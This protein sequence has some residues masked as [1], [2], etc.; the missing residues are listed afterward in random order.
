MN[1]NVYFEVGIGETEITPPEGITGRLG[2]NHTLY[3]KHPIF[4][5]ALAFKTKQGI[6][7]Q[8]TCELVGLTRGTISR[9]HTKLENELGLDRNNIILTC[10]HTHC[11]PWI[12]DLQAKEA[13]QVGI[14]LLDW[15]WL[16]K[17]IQGCVK[18]AQIAIENFQPSILK[19]GVAKVKDVASN[20]IELG[21]RGSICT[22]S[23][24][25]AKGIG[26]IDP[27]IR[28]LSV[29]NI[30]GEIRALFV[31]YSC[32][33]SSYGGGKTQ[34]V[35]PDFPYYASRFISKHFE[36]NIPMSY[37]QGCAGDINVGKFNI[38]GSEE[39]VQGFG[40]RLAEGILR[41]LNDSKEIK[42]SNIIFKTKDLELAVGEWVESIDE[43]RNKFNNLSHQVKTYLERKKPVPDNLVS[44]WRMAIKRLDVCLLSNSKKMKARLYLWKIG[45]LCLVFVPGEWFVH[46]GGQFSKLTN[47]LNIWITTLTDIDLLYIP[48]RKVMQHR[49]WYG[50]NSKMR[51]IS[52][53]SIYT[54]MKTTKDLLLLSG[55]L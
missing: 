53:K 10:T 9:I 36:Q 26:Y 11:S 14:K 24:A 27:E 21:W 43:A 15:H 48:D 52:D 49:E 51:T 55:W 38:Q 4:A 7:V 16:D 28:V 32:H 13:E 42:S 40:K 39:E 20:R 41:A 22:D 45:K 50:V 37:W 31:N 18:S 5:R 19:V 23:F 30:K 35:S 3:I 29:Y 1:K 17:V 2:I 44:Q 54:L 33:P 46:Y 34:F 12:W 25:K 47:Q 8:I 6:I